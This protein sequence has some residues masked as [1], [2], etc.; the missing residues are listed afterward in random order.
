MFQL[1]FV[2][3]F[4]VRFSFW[5][6]DAILTPVSFW[7]R[8]AILTPETWPHWRG[9]ERQGIKHLMNCVNMDPDQWQCGRTKLFVKNPESV[10]RT[11]RLW[12]N[13]AAAVCL[14]FADHSSRNKKMF[15]SSRRACRFGSD[16][17]RVI[18]QPESVTLPWPD[19]GRGP[20]SWQNKFLSHGPR[21]A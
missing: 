21:P 5:P 2:P 14:L 18:V 7:P 19:G 11:G 1:H 12:R 20:L 13:S 9:D 6:W 10:R 8:Y 15:Q 17:S 3:L 4:S 16:G